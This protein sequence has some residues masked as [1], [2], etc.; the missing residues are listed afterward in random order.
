VVELEIT[1]SE[2]EPWGR[3]LIELYPER[4]PI[5]SR[6]FLHYVNSGFYDGTIF[7]R[8]IP[9]FVIQ[10]GGYASL[11]EKKTEGLGEPLRNESRRG[12]LRNARGMV[13][14]AHK[15]DPHSAVSQFFINLGDN[16]QL[17]YPRAGAY[18]YCVFG[19]V[20]EGMDVVDRI[21][22]VP[23]RVSAAAQRR[24]ERYVQEGR[25]VEK[26][27]QSEPL[28]PPILKHARVLD[29]SEFPP[30]VTTGPAGRHAQPK[31]ERQQPETQPAAEGDQQPSEEPTTEPA[32][33]AEPMPEAA[34]DDEVEP[35]PESTP[36]SD[37]EPEA[38][39]QDVPPPEPDAPSLTRPVRPAR[40]TNRP[41]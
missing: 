32:A 15:R 36:A 19:K 38:E 33:E 1:S 3:I 13:A 40:H 34:P 8:V 2:G 21:A 27:E 26:V 18:G 6:N 22:E 14:M 28:S 9:G 24:Y 41:K 39:P 17:D 29:P 5:T 4:T 30:S 20:I 12:T 23:T 7:H 37:V 11:T 35:T 10:G 31:P 25:P 16:E